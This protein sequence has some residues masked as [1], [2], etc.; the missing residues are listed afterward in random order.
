M[1]DLDAGFFQ[2]LALPAWVA[3]FWCRDF[4]VDRLFC[5]IIEDCVVESGQDKAK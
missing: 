5:A 3:L 4:E 1:V 2:Q